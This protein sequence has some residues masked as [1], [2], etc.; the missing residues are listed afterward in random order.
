MIVNSN[1]QYN[2]T[3]HICNLNDQCNNGKQCFNGICGKCS[4]H[5]DCLPLGFSHCNDQGICTYEPVTA[6][7]LF[8]EKDQPE[9][10]ELLSNSSNATNSTN[11]TCST[12]SDCQYTDE[13]SY[14]SFN[15][16]CQY[17][18]LCNNDTDCSA[19]NTYAT[20][21][22]LYPKLKVDSVPIAKMIQIAADKHLIAMAGI[23][24]LTSIV[25]RIASVPQAF[26]IV[27][28]VLVQHP[29]LVI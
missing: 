21:C 7:I 27:T 14:E 24:S 4:T 15:S 1:T 3:I 19:I 5:H 22:Y 18:G 25:L 12:Y 13:Y 16:T 8:L 17:T 28:R 6:A 23:V 9:L 2:H 20:Y 26:S 11:G 10:T 29:C